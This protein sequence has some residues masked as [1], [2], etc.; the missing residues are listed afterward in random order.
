MQADVK[1][2]VNTRKEL[3]RYSR[4]HAAGCTLSQF[5]Q[6]ALL[7]KTSVPSFIHRYGGTL[8]RVF[9]FAQSLALSHVVT[10]YDSSITKYWIGESVFKAHFAIWC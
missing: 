7:F 3:T 6:S 1:V 2:K 4:G 9:G 8:A 5:D 10:D